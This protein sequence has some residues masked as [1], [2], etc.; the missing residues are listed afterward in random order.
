MLLWSH[1]HH[2]VSASP[3]ISLCLFSVWCTC[4][5]ESD[6]C[7]PTSASHSEAF[8]TLCSRHTKYWTYEMR[9]TKSQ[10]WKGLMF[11]CVL[12]HCLYWFHFSR[13]LELSTLN[14]PEKPRKN[15]WRLFIYIRK[16]ACHGAFCIISYCIIPKL[17]YLSLVVCLSH[18]TCKLV[19]LNLWC[20]AIPVPPMVTTSY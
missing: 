15:F 1:L 16:Y 12:E 5:W 18:L 13:F 19:Y 6:I 2:V 17:G 9:Q 11:H 8:Q 10:S 3:L 20:A 14:G 4:L 7:L